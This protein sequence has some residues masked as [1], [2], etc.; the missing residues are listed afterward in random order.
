MK[1]SINLDWLL[2]NPANLRTWRIAQMCLQAWSERYDDCQ[3]L[4]LVKIGHKGIA[5]NKAVH[6]FNSTGWG[7]RFEVRK[8]EPMPETRINAPV[9]RAIRLLVSEWYGACAHI[10]IATWPTRPF[11]SRIAQGVLVIDSEEK[12]TTV[13]KIKVRLRQISLRERLRDFDVWSAYGN[14][15]VARLASTSGEELCSADDIIKFLLKATKKSNKSHR[16]S[17]AWVSPMPPQKT[18]IAEYAESLVDALANKYDMTVVTDSPAKGGDYMENRIAR[19]SMAWL[20]SNG[21]SFDRICY[22]IG[23]SPFHKSISDC[24]E[25]WPGATVLHETSLG[26]LAYSFESSLGGV[27]RRWLTSL[28][29]SSGYRPLI[30]ALAEEGIPRAT[31][32]RYS[33][34][35]RILER[36]LGIITHSQY[37]KAQV[38]EQAYTDPD[39]CTVTVPMCRKGRCLPSRK[40]ARKLLGLDEETYLICSFGMIGEDKLSIPIAEAWVEASSQI[41]RSSKLVF[42]GSN[43]VGSYGK[44]LVKRL[45]TNTTYSQCTITGW[46]DDDQYAIYLAA[47]DLAIQFRTHSRGETSA[48]IYD[49]ICS[50]VRTIINDFA[51]LKEVEANNVILA[52]AHPSIS[53]ITGMICQEALNHGALLKSRE[54]TQQLASLQEAHNPQTCAEFYFSAIEEIYSSKKAIRNQAI[55]CISSKI[56]SREPDI[57]EAARIIEANFPEPKR[58][59]RQLLIDVTQIA[60]SDYKTGIQRVV[61]SLVLQFF[62]LGVEGYRVEPVWLV[63]QPN[64]WHYRYARRWTIKMLG[65][66]EEFLIDTPIRP[67][68][69]DMLFIADLTGGYLVEAENCGVYKRLEEQAVDIAGIVYDILP[70][71]MPHCFPEG[72]KE[73]HEK[74]LR[75]L[76]RRA[77]NMVCISEA[78]ATDTLHWLETQGGVELHDKKVTWF[79]LGADL[80]NS[81]PTKGFPGEL[82]ALEKTLENHMSFLMVGTVEPRKGYQQAFEAFQALAQENRPYCLIIVGKQGWMVDNLANLIRESANSSQNIFWFENASDEFLEWLYKHCDCLLAASEGEGFGLPLIEAAKQQLPVLARDIPVFREVG[83]D[84][85]SYFTANSGGKLARE[86]DQWVQ[87]HQGK[88]TPSPRRIKCL[89]WE[90]SAQELLKALGFRSEL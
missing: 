83:Q 70:I 37:A 88:R 16:L 25:I 55:T 63:S 64:G 41:N 58:R 87:L 24:L 85:A 90:E 73:T 40:E 59:K 84:A 78:V 49:V 47:C 35:Q 61:R 23:N 50:G 44:S 65:Y 4:L 22:H 26:D 38:Q 76:A 45:A 69:G 39:I 66:E 21:K 62:A 28:Y 29:E 56:K 34:T 82:Q 1:L 6:L 13:Q 81:A 36:S 80:E 53:E 52:S 79:H 43:E 67:Q 7:N 30:E 71:Q 74:W 31:I 42:V 8:W 57:H 5:I 46:I 20:N 10:D 72:T 3:L 32:K 60:R 18:G 15:F 54:D 2:E 48:A 77:T 75:S 33:C 27:N 9:N 89:S 17:L 86:I 19:R 14:S 11:Q 12:L 51:S 68:E